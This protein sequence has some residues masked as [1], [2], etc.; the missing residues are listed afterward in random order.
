MIT[1]KLMGAF[2]L[3]VSAALCQVPATLVVNGVG[4]S[5]ATISVADL[6][7][8]PQQTVKVADH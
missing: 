1:P 6:A 5:S 8:L 2:G 7:K 4:G 3:L